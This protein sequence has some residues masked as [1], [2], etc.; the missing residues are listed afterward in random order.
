MS[1]DAAS[2][3][4]AAIGRRLRDARE[5]R[6]MSREAVLEKLHCTPE[7]LAA[8]EQGQFERLGAAVFI[9]GHLRRYADLL[10]EPA[11]DLVAQW[12]GS[13]AAPQPD[14]SQRPQAPR[15]LE[16]RRWVR[17][18]S[19]ALLA[20]VLV[21][22]AWA[23]LRFATPAVRA[24]AP[25]PAQPEALPALRE[26]QPEPALPPAAAPSP[27]PA[28]EAEP[29]PAAAAQ[30][31]GQ[32]ALSGS[33]SEACWVDVTDAAG[34]RL[35]YGLVPAGG[36]VSLSGAAPL[37][38]LVGVQSAAQLEVAGRRVVL[39]SPAPGLRSTRFRLAADGTVLP[40]GD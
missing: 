26:P 18:A 6:G 14:I 11:D 32:V 16:F 25:E 34:R 13:G 40:P 12:S 3:E 35:Y 37:R 28:S 38:V 33:F 7:V 23:V 22:V 31:L 20:M 2:P 17:V 27:A 4:F 24:V 8:L 39:P 36:R 30:P 15:R 19:Y 9:R 5:R 1:E 10:G 29:M 21:G